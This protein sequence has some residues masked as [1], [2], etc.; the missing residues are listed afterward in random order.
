MSKKKLKYVY[1]FS[2]SE[3][4]TNSF[5]MTEINDDAPFNP[6][7]VEF[8]IRPAF[9]FD[10]EKKMIL[11]KIAITYLYEGEEILKAEFDTIY[12][13]DKLSKEEFSNKN[14]L[15][16]LLGISF[17]TIRGILISKTGTCKL[18]D[19]YLPIINPSEI[20]KNEFDTFKSH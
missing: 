2:I 6:D 18:S 5:F 19:I 7:H 9:G 17:S 14:L 13:C 10:K 1:P 20:I 15:A 3:I 4:K 16:S 8:F 11:M 12:K